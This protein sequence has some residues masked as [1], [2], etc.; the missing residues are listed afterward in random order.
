M[1]AVAQNINPNIARKKMPPYSYE[2]CQA[3][4][5]KAARGAAVPADWREHCRGV[6]KPKKGKKPKGKKR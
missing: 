3:F 6:K 1:S 5:A 2:Q 4:A